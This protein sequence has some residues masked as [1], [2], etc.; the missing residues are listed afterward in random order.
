MFKRLSEAL[1]STLQTSIETDKD[2]VEQFVRSAQEQL[3]SNPQSVDEIEAMNAAAMDI[4]SRKQHYSELYEGLREKNRMIKQIQGQGKAL[5]DLESKWRE[6]D[7]RLAAFNEKIAGQR[8][9][10]AEEIDKRGKSLAVELEKMYDRWQEKK[11]KERNQLTHEDAAETSAVM[12][13]MKQQ[14]SELEGRIEKLYTDAKHFNK[15]PPKLQYYEMMQE[16][17][18]QAQATWCRYDEFRKELAELEPEE[19]LTFRKK[20]YFAFQD[21]FLRWQ[22]QLK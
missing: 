2:D 5:Q 18:R 9:R 16:E 7:A 19:W 17:L 6:F 12:G 11:P 8:Q 21:F 10:L 15:A 4:G 3:S 1:V 20:G 14:W 22:E 13:E